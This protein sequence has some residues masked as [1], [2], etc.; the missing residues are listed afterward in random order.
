MGLGLRVF[1]LGLRVPRVDGKW[2]FILSPMVEVSAEL[3][4]WLAGCFGQ[5]GL[6]FAYG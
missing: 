3:V 6:H 1:C 5:G 2:F 4:G